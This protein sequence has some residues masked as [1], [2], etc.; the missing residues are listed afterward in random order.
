MRVRCA[1]VEAACAVHTLDL[2]L[3]IVDGVGR[4]HLEGDSLTRAANVLVCNELVQCAHCR[5]LQGLDEDLHGGLSNRVVIAFL[6][7]MQKGC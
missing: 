4:L 7:V 3:D 6:S 2:G 5:L 1:T